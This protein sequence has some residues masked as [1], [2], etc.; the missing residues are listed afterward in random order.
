[1]VVAT[2]FPVGTSC[3][4]ERLVSVAGGLCTVSTTGSMTAGLPFSE[5]AM[6][7]VLAV[8]NLEKPGDMHLEENILG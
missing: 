7:V 1:M 5:C 4:I 8:R 2:R 3:D 6:W